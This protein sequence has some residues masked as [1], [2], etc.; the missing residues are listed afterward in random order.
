[1]CDESDWVT[2]EMF[3]NAALVEIWRNGNTKDDVQYILYRWKS[4]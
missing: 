4:S 1:M 2:W 3:V